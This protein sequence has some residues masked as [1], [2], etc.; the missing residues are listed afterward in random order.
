MSASTIVAATDLSEMGRFAVDC[1]MSQ[2]SLTG[3][4]VLIVHAIAPP[5]PER[6]EGM[7]HGGVELEDPQAV[8][9]RLR[10]IEPS[11]EGAHFEHRLVRGEPA[12]EIL[13]LAEEESAEMIVMGTHGRKG[14]MR[15]LMGSVA[16]Q[17][18]R[19]ATC[20]VLLV[21]LPKPGA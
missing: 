6:G 13:R 17:V 15:A 5:A 1:A 19:N 14:V 9:R 12:S 8:E 3:A 21:K 4:R 11:T 7:L 2:A 18:A 10:A 20:P 16:E